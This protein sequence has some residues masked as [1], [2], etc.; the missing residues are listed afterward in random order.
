[1]SEFVFHLFTKNAI[2]NP[3]Q[4]WISFNVC[5]Y[6]SSGF[7]KFVITLDDTMHGKEK[8]TDFSVLNFPSCFCMSIEQT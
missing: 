7:M 1:M 4:N 5:V 3:V 6:M 2:L 8:D